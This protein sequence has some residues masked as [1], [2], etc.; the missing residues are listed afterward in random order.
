MRV[1]CKIP[2]KSLQTPFGI[3]IV[4]GLFLGVGLFPA[5]C[6]DA[7]ELIWTIDE[8]QRK[9][10]TVA[11]HFSQKKET[12]LLREPLLS[13]GWVKFKRPDQIHW[14]YVKPEPMEVAL[15]GKTLWLYTPGRSQAKQYSLVR[16]KRIAQYLDPL[17][18][19]FQKTF[20]ELTEAYAVVYEGLTADQSF[21]FRLQPKDERVQRLLSR[22]DLWIDKSSG[23]IL[24][25]KMREPNG[26]QLSL[27]FE[28][29]QINPLLTDD[30]L[31]VK[32]PPSA[33]VLEQSLP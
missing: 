30:D 4:L 22:V 26:D 18:A 9:I 8:Q 29:L 33:R 12:S 14:T 2:G 31:K 11:A 3:L 1:D 25:C 21:Y 16:G 17:T 15:D 13:S 27:E 19:I 7:A 23:A 6:Q 24:R 20:G 10:Q 5:F 28:N 32:I